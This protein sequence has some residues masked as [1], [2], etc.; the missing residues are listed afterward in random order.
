MMEVF[1]LMC[2]STGRCERSE[3]EAR[4]QPGDARRDDAGDVAERRTRLEICGG[5]RRRVQHV[6]DVEV[7]VEAAVAAERK[8]LAPAEVQDVLRRQLAAAV[9]LEPDRRVAVL[10]DWRPAVGIGLPEDVGALAEQ[11]VLALQESGNREIGGGRGGGADG[12]G[13]PPRLVPRGGLGG[14]APQPPPGPAAG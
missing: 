11:A 7:D 12:A 8:A 13:P 5:R 14:G 2:A 10:R 9:R 3:P 4:P 6:E 1:R